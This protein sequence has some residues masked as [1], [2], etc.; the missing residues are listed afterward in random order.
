MWSRIRDLSGSEPSRSVRWYGGCSL[1]LVEGLSN[2]RNQS[3]AGRYRYAVGGRLSLLLVVL[4]C[5]VWLPQLIRGDSTPLVVKILMAAFALVALVWSAVQTL[6][7]PVTVSGAG[8]QVRSRVRLVAEEFLWDDLA[9]Y[10]QDTFTDRQLALIANSNRIVRLPEVEQPTDLEVQLGK[11]LSR[12]PDPR[13][14]GAT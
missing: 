11:K 3:P 13:A 6:L 7:P 5:V 9:G 10:C 12:L 4:L 1:G 2:P 8:V 14:P